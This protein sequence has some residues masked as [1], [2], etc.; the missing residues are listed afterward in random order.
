VQGLI[1][2][3][4]YSVL[5]AVECN[6][7]RFVV[8]RN[9]W[10]KSEWTGR[11][12]DGSKEWTQEW[13]QFLPEL[14][15]QFGNDGQFLMECELALSYSFATLIYTFS[16]DVDWLDCFYQI[17]RTILFDETWSMSSQWLQVTCPPLPSVWSHGEVSCMAQLLIV[18]HIPELIVFSQVLSFRTDECHNC[19]LPT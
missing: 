1:G 10:G 17:D 14:G 3:H 12:S 19:P 15:H 7:K 9:P 6:G 16:P 18:V 8:V 5:R 4:S 2:D 13:L 11:W